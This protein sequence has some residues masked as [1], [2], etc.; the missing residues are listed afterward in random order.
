MSSSNIFAVSAQ[1]RQMEQNMIHQNVGLASTEVKPEVKSVEKS[2]TAT[3]KTKKPVKV[4]R[5]RKV[6]LDATVPVASKDK[7]VSYAN[8]K[9]LSVSVVLQ[10]LIDDNCV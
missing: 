4:Q 10:M 8:K 7:L 3:T 9:G 6:R 5:Q 2:T 1:K